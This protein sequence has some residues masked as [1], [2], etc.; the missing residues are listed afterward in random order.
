MIRYALR[1]AN[2]HAFEAWFGGSAAFEAQ[3][4]AGLVTCPECG[5]ADV[6]KALMA[7]AVSTARARENRSDPIETDATPQAEA[8]AQGAAPS[9]TAPPVPAPVPDAPM[10][11]FRDPRAAKLVEMVR[12]VK[13]ELMAKAEDVGTAFPEEARKIHYGEADERGIYGEAT[14]EDAEA[15]LEEGIDVMPIPTLPEDRN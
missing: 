4:E 13:A 12:A 3:R 6:D 10:P 15:L 11:V 9:A 5:T 14:L 1:C 7:P 2:G 8:P